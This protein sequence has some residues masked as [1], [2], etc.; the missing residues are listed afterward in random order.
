[1][2][3]SKRKTENSRVNKCLFSFRLCQ[4]SWHKYNIFIGSKIV[5]KSC[6]EIY[7]FIFTIS[8]SSSSH[9][10]RSVKCFILSEEERNA[11][12]LKCWNAWW[13]WW[14]LLRNNNFH[15]LIRNL[16]MFTSLECLHFSFYC[17]VNFWFHFTWNIW[18]SYPRIISLTLN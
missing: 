17:M 3:M 18:T 13:I 16:S 6:C 10:F 12:M 11:E 9:T 1:M 2:K 14:V 5:L 7:K 15:F 4:W 8:S